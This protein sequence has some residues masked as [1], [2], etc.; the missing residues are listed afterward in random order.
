N[1][2]DAIKQI[3]NNFSTATGKRLILTMAPETAFIQGGM[4]A[5]GGIWGAY[6]PIVDALRD[7][8]EILHVQLYNSGSMYGIDGNIYTQG[9]AD[10]IIAMTE[11]VI[12]GFNTAGGAFAGL[13][14]QKI[15]VGLPA[16]TSA[17]GG[18]YVDTAS[19]AAALRY[20]TGIG[21]QPGSY[22]L[23]NPNAYPNLRGM[24][25]WSVNWDA[26]ANCN[27][28]Y[29]YAQN[30]Q[31]LFSTST[32]V[33]ESEQSNNIFTLF[34]NPAGDVLHIKQQ[35]Y[36]TFTN[37]AIIINHMGMQVK[38]QTIKADHTTIDISDLSSGVYFIRIGE[39]DIAFVKQ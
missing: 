11:A 24:M 38:K 27:G 26:V 32:D 22:V 39:K 2:I 6:L 36:N 8:L 3:M 15:A 33:F 25:T 21:P 34:P 29:T 7:S 37:D 17:A 9:T 13:P 35:H 18:G 4:S 28:T 19:V 16:C 23:F 5:Y 20:L 10:F 30:F 1:L 14:E 12:Q 31:N